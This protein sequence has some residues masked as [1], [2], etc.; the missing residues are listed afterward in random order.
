MESWSSEEGDEYSN[1][2]AIES[3][4]KKEMLSELSKWRI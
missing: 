1:V 2:A 4:Q 3:C